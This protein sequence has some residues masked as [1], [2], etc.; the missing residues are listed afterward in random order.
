[1]TS[2]RLW[3]PAVLVKTRVWMGCS[4]SRAHKTWPRSFLLKDFRQCKF[5]LLC[6][7]VTELVGQEWNKKVSRYMTSWLNLPTSLLRTCL[8]AGRLTLNHLPKFP[9]LPLL[10]TP[11]SH[12]NREVFN[13]ICLT[14]AM[15]KENTGLLR[16]FLY[17]ILLCTRNNKK[18]YR[19][20][21]NST[22]D[23]TLLKFS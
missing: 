20:W 10:P 12:R 21:K 11:P 16:P 19:K 9:L 17:S 2:S 6:L 4:V 14:P 22:L 8:V 1:M 15:W 7:A 23:V 13:Y 18:L 5:P 3:R